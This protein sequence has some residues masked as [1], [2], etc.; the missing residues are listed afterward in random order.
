M[1]FRWSAKAGVAG[2]QRAVGT[3]Q[4][5]MLVS[6]SRV[7]N[8]APSFF[9]GRLKQMQKIQVSTTY[10]STYK[11][12]MYI[13]VLYIPYLQIPWTISEVFPNIPKTSASDG[14]LIDLVY[15]STR[16]TLW[17]CFQSRQVL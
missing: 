8:N 9:A 12:Y 5:V 10:S 3:E 2:G 7:V 1:F 17:M 14:F 15:I 13:L 6:I 11:L 4:M 16:M